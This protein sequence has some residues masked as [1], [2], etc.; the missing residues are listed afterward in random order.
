[1]IRSCRWVTAAALNP[2]RL[3]TA[4]SDSIFVPFAPPLRAAPDKTEDSLHQWKGA[5]HQLLLKDRF[6]AQRVVA[7]LQ[8]PKTKLAFG[9]TF[10]NVSLWPSEAD[11]ARQTT[12]APF[13]MQWGGGGQTSRIDPRDAYHVTL[14]VVTARNRT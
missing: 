6:R 9:T 12:W 7:A 2:P 11:V 5:L 10:A 8:S 13:A 14:P 1:M 4:G 3:I